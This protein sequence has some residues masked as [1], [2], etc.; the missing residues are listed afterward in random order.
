LLVGLHLNMLKLILEYDFQ[1]VC[2]LSLVLLVNKQ[3]D[4]ML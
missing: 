2:F 4:D 3:I 1:F